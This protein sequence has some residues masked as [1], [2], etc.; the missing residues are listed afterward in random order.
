MTSL[1][2]FVVPSSTPFISESSVASAGSSAVQ[3]PRLSRSDWDGTASTT[4]SA[5]VSASS[6]SA[7]ARTASGSRMPGR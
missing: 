7:V 6:A 1:I 5:P 2:R 3:R 4:M